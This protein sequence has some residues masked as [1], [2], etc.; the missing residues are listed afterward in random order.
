V[1]RL[2]LGVALL[3]PVA[4]PPAASSVAGGSDDCYYYAVDAPP[5]SPEGR[6]CPPMGSA[7]RGL[8]PPGV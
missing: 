6:L 8:L 7:I 4:G 2:L 1:R 5:V 3:V